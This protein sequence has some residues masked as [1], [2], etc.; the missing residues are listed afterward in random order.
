MLR[1]NPSTVKTST[2]MAASTSMAPLQLSGGRLEMRSERKL[3]YAMECSFPYNAMPVM[4]MVFFQT[5]E[6]CAGHG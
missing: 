6:G 5:A 4:L 1:A 3:L 2:S